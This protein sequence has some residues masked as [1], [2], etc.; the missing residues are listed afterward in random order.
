[1]TVPGFTAQASLGR[2]SGTYRRTMGAISSDRSIQPAFSVLGTIPRL[3][4][5]LWET[6]QVYTVAGSTFELCFCR[7]WA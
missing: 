3:P 2:A 4:Y 1:M 5:C 7:L 6:C